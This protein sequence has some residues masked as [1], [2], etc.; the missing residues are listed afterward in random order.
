MPASAS[1]QASVAANRPGADY[2]NIGGYDPVWGVRCMQR[3]TARLGRHDPLMSRPFRVL[4]RPRR[5]ASTD[6]D[7]IMPVRGLSGLGSTSIFIVNRA[8]AASTG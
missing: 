5:Q 2:A 3:Q 8:A 6:N 4:T 7:V 1:R